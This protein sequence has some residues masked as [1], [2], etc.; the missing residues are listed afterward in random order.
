MC[1]CTCTLLICVLGTVAFCLDGRRGAPGCVRAVTVPTMF[2]AGFELADHFAGAP[3]DRALAVTAAVLCAET[4]PCRGGAATNHG[5]R[6]LLP[7]AVL[8]AVPMS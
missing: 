4:L 3:F 2:V 7:A 8:D 5:A 1:V 6:P